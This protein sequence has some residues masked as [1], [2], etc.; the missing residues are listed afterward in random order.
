MVALSGTLFGSLFLKRAAEPSGDF[1][2]RPAGGQI[3][4][5]RQE[6]IQTKCVD[7]S[8]AIRINGQFCGLIGAFV[9]NL[10]QLA[11]RRCIEITEQ[12]DIQ[13]SIAFFLRSDTKTFC[14]ASSFIGVS[15]SPY[16]NCRI[17]SC[18]KAA[19]FSTFKD[20]PYFLSLDLPPA[21]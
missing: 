11:C 18:D 19:S 5:A 1:D 14:H 4:Q 12:L 16:L 20:D 10:D 2:I 3:G 17:K 6:Y 7:V 8:Q 9:Q 21:E 13:G 15:S